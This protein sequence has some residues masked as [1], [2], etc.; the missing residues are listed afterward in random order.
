MISK[1]LAILT[2][3]RPPLV[4]SSRPG[5]RSSNW[6]RGR[7]CGLLLDTPWR[8]KANRSRAGV[9][10]VMVHVGDRRLVDPH[11][12]GRGEF[13]TKADQYHSQK[14][15]SC[16]G[17]DDQRAGRRSGHPDHLNGCWRVPQLHF[18]TSATSGRF[19]RFRATAM[20]FARS[21]RY[22]DRFLF[23]SIGHR[24]HARPRHYVGRCW[25]CAALMGEHWTGSSPFTIR[26]SFRAGEGP[27][28]CTGWICR[29]MC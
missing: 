2:T 8:I 14:M 26:T 11:V 17:P 28:R 7:D 3:P 21:R 9:R 13:R 20:P 1:K 4:S 5:S 25:C 29:A 18:D 15:I 23:G 22:P 6:A 12:S 24:A 10:V 27:P 16:F 19:V